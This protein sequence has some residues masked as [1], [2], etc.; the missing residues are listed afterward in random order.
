MKLTP[1]DIRGKEFKRAMRGDIDGEV[2]AFLDEIA[3]EFERFFKENIEL[4]E[5]GEAL[6]ERIDRT[7]ISKRPFEPRWSRPSAA[8][9]SSGPTLRRKP[10]SH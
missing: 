5:R 8:P 4:T 3:D 10:S 7:A 2:D 9:R 6:Q 1:P